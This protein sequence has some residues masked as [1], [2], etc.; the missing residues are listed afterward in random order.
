[1]RNLLFLP[2]GA[3]LVIA[4]ADV[5]QNGFVNVEIKAEVF[6]YP[7]KQGRTER[8]LAQEGRLLFQADKES[9]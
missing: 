4:A 5:Q 8:S 6:G 7:V 1:M 2:A 3:M 9:Q